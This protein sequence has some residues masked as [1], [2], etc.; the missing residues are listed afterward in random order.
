MKRYASIIF[1]LSVF[2]ITYLLAISNLHTSCYR[3]GGCELIIDKTKHI[4]YKE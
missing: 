3:E 1:C 2:L 4:L